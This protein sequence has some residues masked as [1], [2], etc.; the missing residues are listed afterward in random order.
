MNRMQSVIVGMMSLLV[1]AACGELPSAPSE[2]D[3]K[4]EVSRN[5]YACGTGWIDNGNGSFGCTT[6]VSEC[7]GSAAAYFDG[8]SE[9]DIAL[10]DDTNPFGFCGGSGSGVCFQYSVTTS[11]C[12]SGS[13]GA[14]G[15]GSSGGNIPPAEDSVSYEEVV[16]ATD[17][18]M[19]QIDEHIAEWNSP[20]VALMG[21]PPSASA[22]MLVTPET[23]IDLLVLGY[24]VSQLVTAGPSAGRLAAVLADL[25]A[26]IIPGLPAPGSL[27]ILAK[28]ALHR[29]CAAF[30]WKD[31]A[32]IVART[33]EIMTCSSAMAPDW[34]SI[35]GFSPDL[36][37]TRAHYVPCGARR[38][39]S[40][41]RLASANAAKARVVF[42]ARPR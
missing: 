26:T 14:N 23:A 13:G 29:P 32:S 28:E 2:R 31:S 35:P 38:C 8:C 7:D 3:V 30:V 1:L 21:E 12:G 37:H 40:R 10:C 20:P 6:G 36:R 22:Q 18:I 19:Q 9:Q 5:F 17:S 4:A 42:L 25:G 34:G 11:T 24:D 16:A 39:R 41:Y 15:G 27:K 33:P